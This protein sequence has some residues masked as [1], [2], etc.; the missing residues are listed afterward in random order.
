MKLTIEDLRTLVH[1]A[2]VDSPLDTEFVLAEFDRVLRLH[3]AFAWEKGWNG[4]FYDRDNIYGET[5]ANP[6]AVEEVSVG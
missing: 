5:V 2:A 1:V 4:G 6:Y 3:A